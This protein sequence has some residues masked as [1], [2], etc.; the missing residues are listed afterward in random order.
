MPDANPAIAE[1]R[2]DS[3]SELVIG[4]SMRGLVV[5]HYWSPRAGPCLRLMPRLVELARLF[6]G[7]FLLVVANTDEIGRLA[8]DQGVTS[9]PTVKFYRDGAVVHTIHGA[10][11]DSTF[12]AALNRFLG[13]VTDR[14]RAEALAA[15]QAG[16][17]GEAIEC[18]AR[19]AVERPDDLSI[20]V[21]LAK[22][23]L[24][25]EQPE[26]ALALL[27]ALPQEARR[28]GRVAPLLAHLEL[29]DAARHGPGDVADPGAAEP[30]DAEILL[31]M[32]ARALFD[33]RM[34]DALDSLLRLAT[35]HAGWRDDIGRRAMIALFD[36][37]GANH[38]LTRVY[39][40]R[41]AHAAT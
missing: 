32:A 14:Q 10:E 18:L 6:E 35:D 19:A 4:N 36:M 34:P 30:I 26:R 1:V 9:V 5:V 13:D 37:L 31:T 33:D 20:S 24:L 22:L 15:H 39:R 28:D 40:A 21:D 38:E 8:R 41:L 17:T 23:L 27:A 7:R 29:I 25:D 11:P 12:R 2:P 16:R 3:F